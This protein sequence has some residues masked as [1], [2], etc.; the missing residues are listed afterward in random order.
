VIIADTGFFLAVASEDDAHHGAA[1]DA[2]EL[3]TA[4][5]IT[6][7]PVVTETSHLLLH[8]VGHAA[9]LAFIESA[10]AGAFQI[11]DL[12]GEHWPRI[13][14]LMKQYADLPMDLADASLV[15]LAEEQNDGRILTTDQRD[16]KTYRWKSKKPFTN[17]LDAKR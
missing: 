10:K 8:R 17:L 15:V 11:F 9:L 1:T 14:K 13:V 3:L 16:F 4:P 7:W 12:R 5:L 6:T 2:V